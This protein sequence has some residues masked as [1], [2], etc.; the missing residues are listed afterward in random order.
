MIR[1]SEKLPDFI[2][3]S[4][5]QARTHS[6]RIKPWMRGQEDD[7]CANLGST[8]RRARFTGRMIPFNLKKMVELRKCRLWRWI[9]LDFPISGRK[10]SC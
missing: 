9:A 1:S 3:W 4:S 2:V 7:L 10:T 6:N 5:S 8:D